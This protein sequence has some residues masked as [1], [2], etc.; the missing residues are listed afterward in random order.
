M[1]RQPNH[2]KSRDFTEEDFLELTTSIRN[3]HS[4]YSISSDDCALYYGPWWKY[5][6]AEGK[7]SKDILFNFLDI[8]NPK[9]TSEDFFKKAKKGGEKTGLKW[10]HRE[11]T[12]Y[13][14][15]LLLQGG[16]PLK[17]I[18][19]YGTYYREFLLK[20]IE[21]KPLEISDI[22]NNYELTRNLPFSI[23]NE[24][25]FQAALDI[26]KAIWDETD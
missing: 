14:R 11:N 19:R 8:E 21:N 23:R 24:Y 5:V 16:I 22:G 15:T 26:S 10:I 17:N 2:P 20:V 6:Y 1:N 7:P 9:F 4:F 3:S 18:R 25:V 12:H 13:F